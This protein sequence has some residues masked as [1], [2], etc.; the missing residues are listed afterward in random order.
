MNAVVVLQNKERCKST[1][2]SRAL[3]LEISRTSCACLCTLV[4]HVSVTRLSTA[5]TAVTAT[6]SVWYSGRTY[7]HVYRMFWCFLVGAVQD[8][9]LACR[10]WLQHCHF[11]GCGFQGTTI[12]FGTR[13]AATSQTTAVF[14]EHRPYYPNGEGVLC[15]PHR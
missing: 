2:P 3:H 6:F 12:L 5:R 10:R 13:P 4:L 14:G 11:A 8:L 9:V 1:H 7:A 15:Q